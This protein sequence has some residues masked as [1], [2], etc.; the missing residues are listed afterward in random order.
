MNEIWST[1]EIVQIC[2][3]DAIVGKV[4]SQMFHR[5]NRIV[6]YTLIFPLLYT[7]NWYMETIVIYD[8]PT[9]WKIYLEEKEKVYLS[10]SHIRVCTNCD[11]Q[12]KRLYFPRFLCIDVA[13]WHKTRI[14]KEHCRRDK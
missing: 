9:R 13:C 12:C 4:S 3:T 2:Q 8:G 14:F 6:A 1:N 7:V 5:K 10:Q 11:M